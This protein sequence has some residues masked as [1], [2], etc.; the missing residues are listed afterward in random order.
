MKKAEYREFCCRIVSLEKDF[1]NGVVEMVKAV[2]DVIPDSEAGR[3][4]VEYTQRVHNTE[5]D[6]GPQSFEEL[7]HFR[8]AFGDMCVACQRRCLRELARFAHEKALNQES[9][10]WK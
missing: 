8:A 6:F 1:Q 9:G 2:P 7:R 3:Q 5:F 4:M 10:N